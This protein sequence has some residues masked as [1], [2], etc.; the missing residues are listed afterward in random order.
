M[1]IVIPS[2]SAEIIADPQR[3]V[4]EMRRGRII[5]LTDLGYMIAPTADIVGLADELA[6][7][8]LLEEMV[9]YR[10]DVT[11][12]DNT[13]FISPKGNTRL[14]PRV[15]LAIDPPDSID[16]RGKTASV[17]IGDG[18]VLIGEIP[19]RLLE[20][21]RRFI[22]ANREA[23]LDYWEYRIDTEALRRRLKSA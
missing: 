19:P 17:A 23:L 3:F 16:P 6:E 12:V 10:K 9:S 22:D 14:G 8:E 13:I 20:Q 11:G 5:N 7:A 15:E 18:A 2:S 4:E 1:T 21:V